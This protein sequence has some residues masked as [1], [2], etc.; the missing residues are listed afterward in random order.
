MTSN[1][2]SL[3]TTG[4]SPH[5]ERRHAARAWTD[6]PVDVLVNGFSHHCRVM[7]ISLTG[8][9]VELTRPLAALTP[10]LL[11]TYGVQVNA[12]QN[13]NL[14][15]RTVWRQG[16]MQAVCFVGLGDDDQLMI[17]ETVALAVRRLATD[18]ERLDL[19]EL[20]DRLGEVGFH[21]AMR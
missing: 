7:D 3:A 9:L 14:K 17:A 12:T 5:H 20:R 16:A 15:A 4:L 2:A 1:T 6:L 8:M 13:L 21:H 11:G 18:V 19:A 10:Q